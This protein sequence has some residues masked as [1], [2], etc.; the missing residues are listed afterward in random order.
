MVFALGAG[1]CSYQVSY[2]QYYRSEKT[3]QDMTPIT[4]LVR[5][6]LLVSS[7]V[8]NS[9]GQKMLVD[10]LVYDVMFDLDGS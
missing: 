1:Y 4:C 2:A 6:I 7:I 9:E 3:D 5:V 8:Q 10:S